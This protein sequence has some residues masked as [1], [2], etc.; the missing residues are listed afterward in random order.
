MT[1]VKSHE[2]S[3]HKASSQMYKDDKRRGTK[4]GNVTRITAN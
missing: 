2:E 3:A 1:N 4:P